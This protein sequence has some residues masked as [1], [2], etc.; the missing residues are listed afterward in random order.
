MLWIWFWF[1]YKKWFLNNGGDLGFPYTYKDIIGKGRS[2]FTG[3]DNNNDGN[4]KIKEIEVFKIY[5]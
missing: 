1:V 2:I 4:F 5:K 3:K